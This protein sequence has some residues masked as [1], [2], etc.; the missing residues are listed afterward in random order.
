[1]ANTTIADFRENVCEM[2]GSVIDSDEPLS[3][4]T[5]N[6]KSFLAIRKLLQKPA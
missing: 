2:L 1:M 3:I 5:E 6:T 4:S